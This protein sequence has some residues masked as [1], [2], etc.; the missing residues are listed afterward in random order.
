[1]LNAI[2]TRNCPDVD[3]YDLEAALDTIVLETATAVYSAYLRAGSAKQDAKAEADL[4]Y[5]ILWGA[6]W[7]TP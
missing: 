1:M 3:N 7:T 4:V 2:T 6:I 5:R